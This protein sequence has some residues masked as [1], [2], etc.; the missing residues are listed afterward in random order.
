MF[1]LY[2]D[3][4]KKHIE[5]RQEKDPDYNNGQILVEVCAVNICGSD[6][7]YF[8]HGRCGSYVIKSPLILGHEG[9]GRVAEI[10]SGTSSGPAKGGR[11]FINPY[12]FCG[13]CEECR[14]GRENFCRFGK[15]MGT[16]SVTPHNHGLLRQYVLLPAEQYLPAPDHIPYEHL[17]CAEPLSVVLH[18]ATRAGNI[19][20][21]R[22]AVT[23]AGP[24]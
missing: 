16:A 2:Y 9:S 17:A 11:V 6:M 18:A 20:G 3:P 1:S 24:A 15:F 22:I 23:G 13:E 7:H 14:D 12:H 21:K 19:A 10:G 4:R 8:S 5:E